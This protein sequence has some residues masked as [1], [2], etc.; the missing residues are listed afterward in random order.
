MFLY[1]TVTLIGSVMS[2]ST[3]Q[4]HING[5][6][7]NGVVPKKQ[8]CKLVAKPAPDIF[9]IQGVYHNEAQCKSYT[10]ANSTNTQQGL[11][12]SARPRDGKPNS[13]LCMYIYIY[14]HTYTY[15]YIYTYVYR[16]RERSSASLGREPLRLVRAGG[17]SRFVVV[18]IIVVVVVI[19]IVI[20]LIV[21][22]IV[23]IVMLRLGS[24][25]VRPGLSFRRRAVASAPFN[26]ILYYDKV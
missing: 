10:D 18:I 7:S 1:D 24:L 12:T 16:E 11:R 3:Y 25:E 17:V 14:I 22:I 20:I 5:V 6:V 8:I 26:I 2:W 21:I 13:L 9:R 15:I 4:R 19:I 23:I